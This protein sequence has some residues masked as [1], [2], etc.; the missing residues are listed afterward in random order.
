[1]DALES[2]RRDVLETALTGLNLPREELKSLLEN[3][4][5]EVDAD[6][7]LPCFALARK[8]RRSPQDIAADASLGMKAV[9]LVKGVDASGSYLNFYADWGKL[10]ALLL[11]EIL[12]KKG[13]YGSGEAKKQKIMVEFA[14]PNTHKAF[15]VGHVR[16]ISFGE[17][18]SRLLGFAGF[19]VVRANY[20]GDIGPHVAKCVWGLKNLGLKTPDKNRGVWLGRVYANASKR[21]SGKKELEEEVKEINRKL[22][23]GEDKK[24]N[25]MLKETR[26]WSLDYFDSVYRDFGAR[27]DRLYFESEVEG[28]GIKLAKELLK[29]EIAKKSEGAIVMDLKKWDLGVYVLLTR[30]G[31]PLYSV[32]D[33]ILAGLQEKEFH[34]DRIIHVVG[35]EQNLHFKQLFKSLERVNPKIAKKEFHLSY[36]LVN[37]KSGK[38]A[39]REGTVITYDELKKE[40]LSHAASETKKHARAEGSVGGMKKLNEM[41]A[42]GAIKYDMVKQSPEKVIVFDWKQALSFD[43]NAAPYLQ[44]TH[45]RCSS[46]F[47]KGGIKKPGKF[48]ARHLN[49]KKEILLMK[50]LL[51]FPEAVQAAARDMRPHYIANYVFELATLF[52]DFYQNVPVLKS[53][54]E[55]EARLALVKASQQAI[56]NSLQLLGI[57]APDRM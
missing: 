44:Y 51:L 25:S 8:L 3:P 27:F 39:S 37:L 19:G 10:G 54:K 29:K 36:E 46:I 16:N 42:T 26:K 49:G 24:L 31:T 47:E 50:K 32:K 23:S 6:L 48:E 45:A 4:P 15:H 38:M 55:R 1:M 14:H 34:P 17:A 40:V 9:G 13:K 41:I 5:K 22:Y 2:F 56:H 18:L 12:G 35:T 33:F 57:E 28:P 11:K 7:A 30:D 52:N 20:Q 43:G 21:I 53:G